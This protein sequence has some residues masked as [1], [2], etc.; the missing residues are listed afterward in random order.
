[1]NAN[2]I[3]KN[4]SENDI[5][6]FLQDLGGEPYKQGN[7]I[8]SRTICHNP[9]HNGSHKLY[10][11]IDRK[12]FHCFTECSCSYDIFSLIEQVK[13]MDF[14]ESLKYTKEYFGYSSD[15][16]SVDY[17]EQIDM[18]FFNTFN[19]KT[20]FKKLPS[21]NEKV[22]R[23]FDD[24][25]HVSWVKDYIS[26]DIMKKYNIKLDILKQ[27]IIIPHYDIDD[28][29]VGIRVRNLDEDMVERGMK[30]V[31]LFTSK[32]TNYRHMT[33]SNLYGLNV[34]KNNIEAV[35]KVVLFE[36]E[37]SVL[38]LDTFYGGKGIGVGVSGAN[39]SEYQRHILNKLDI[40]EVVIAFDKEFYKIGDSLEKFYAEKIEKTIINK[41]KASYNVSVIWD[42]K[43][44]LDYKDSPTDKGK[45]VWLELWDNRIRIN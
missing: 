8:I 25:Y 2:N 45:D 29:L 3:K 30:Y 42:T 19:K 5:F 40:E 39:L 33:G 36:G 38:A 1:M 32:T 44:L 12:F 23:V 13:G 10:Y 35:K 26:P 28:R 27:R 9:P 41:L 4:I 37:K 16:S 22:L 14:K 7:S 18:S 20:E 17:S 6:S 21:Y 11:D 43:D 34:T 24:K 31:P 15:S